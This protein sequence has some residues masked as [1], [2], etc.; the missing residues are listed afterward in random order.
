MASTLREGVEATA[1]AV[2]RDIKALTSI[3]R[4]T[5][6]ET[7]T[8]IRASMSRVIHGSVVTKLLKGA[9]AVQTRL[10]KTDID[11]LI[12]AFGGDLKTIGTDVDELA[13]SGKGIVE[14]SAD[15]K[16]IDE[17]AAGATKPVDPTTDTS[18]MTKVYNSVVSKGEY[19]FGTNP[20]KKVAALGVTV[21]V[22]TV[23]GIY[24]STNDKVFN[25]KALRRSGNKGTILIDF[26]EST[27]TLRAAAW[28]INKGDSIALDK[29][30][31]TLLGPDLGAVMGIN[32][33]VVDV[34][35]DYQ[36][37]VKINDSF[38]LPSPTPAITCTFGAAASSTGPPNCGSFTVHSSF[39]AG[40][41]AALGAVIDPIIAAAAAAADKLKSTV[42]PL[43]TNAFVDFLKTIF[44]ALGLGN[45]G[46][47]AMIVVFVI[48]IL[49]SLS[50]SMAIVYFSTKK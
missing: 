25:I 41:V 9:T 18:W 10:S 32:L 30:I 46:S 35:S 5:A 42:V 14:G 31:N 11:D 29:E 27:N 7:L 21:T 48:V 3:E 6:L 19:L 22:A 50:S 28:A 47:T 38:E 37:E 45:I 2:A 17:A 23:A 8:V 49:L 12:K 39:A 4:A 44:S 1:G 36:I 26:E 15:P 13:K 20:V 40:I 16:A 24:G 34:P 43:V 33:K